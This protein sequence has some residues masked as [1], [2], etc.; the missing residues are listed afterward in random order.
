MCPTRTDNPASP[1][2]TGYYR[3][4]VDDGRTDDKIAAPDPAAAPVHTDAESGG[5]GTSRSESDAST[6]VQRHRRAPEQVAAPHTNPGRAQW[7][8]PGRGQAWSMGAGFAVMIL[9]GLVVAIVTLP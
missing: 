9:L 4:A 2:D 1:V 8:I 7:Q 5:R 3:A 6:H